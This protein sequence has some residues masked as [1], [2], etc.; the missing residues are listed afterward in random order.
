M[1]HTYIHTAS[2]YTH[3]DETF[4]FYVAEGCKVDCVHQAL[5]IRPKQT[6][7]QAQGEKLCCCLLLRIKSALSGDF[8]KKSTS[9]IKCGM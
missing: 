5:K 9:K 4:Y 1:A 2:K 3:I 6:L 7:T 8:R